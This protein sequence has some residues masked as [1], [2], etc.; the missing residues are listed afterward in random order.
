MYFHKVKITLFVILAMLCMAS[1]S[2][3]ATLTLTNID[4]SINED[5]QTELKDDIFEL[6]NYVPGDS[7][8]QTVIFLG[9]PTSDGSPIGAFGEIQQGEFTAF[10]S[11][12][13]TIQ[14]SDSELMA[15]FKPNEHWNGVAT[16]QWKK[17]DNISTTQ[18]MTGTIN[19]TAINDIATIEELSLSTNENVTLNFTTQSFLEKY[20][21]IDNNTIDGIIIGPPRISITISDS[22]TFVAKDHTGTNVNIFETGSNELSQNP[23][24]K[25]IRNTPYDINTTHEFNVE[26]GSNDFATSFRGTLILEENATYTCNDGASKTIT[27]TP[28]IDTINGTI[29]PTTFENK[30]HS[31]YT[32]QVI[33]DL[34]NIKFVPK[35]DWYGNTTLTWQAYTDSTTNQ[36]SNI[37][38]INISVAEIGENTPF[39]EGFS[40]TTNEDTS[41]TLRE[42]QFTS[43]YSR[44]DGNPLQHIVFTQVSTKGT[45]KLVNEP[46]TLE[47]SLDISKDNLSNLSFKPNDDAFGTTVFKWK[48][49]DGNQFSNEASITINITEVNDPPKF[50]EINFPSYTYEDDNFSFTPTVIEPDI[51]EHYINITEEEGTTFNI[52][53]PKNICQPQSIT[54][55]PQI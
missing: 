45:L 4:Q 14:R 25:L 7:N 20:T 2:L 10:T 24:L 38:T 9:H 1:N 53:L 31:G 32:Y 33:R 49:Y 42:E 21:D 16:F 41:I 35:K 29:S 23:D 3:M 30:S 44:G 40:I 36:V 48:A 50:N 43:N 6:S 18:E 17:T 13:K 28:L 55:G 5:R 46:I 37:A 8:N 12:P 19:V 34:D 52:S 51:K 47:P 22:C 39:I 26:S 27:T 15:Y 54:S 11:F